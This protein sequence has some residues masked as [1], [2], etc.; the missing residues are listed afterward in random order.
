MTDY[1][2]LTWFCSINEDIIEV[3]KSLRKSKMSSSDR[4][5]I[6]IFFL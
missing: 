5:I 4:F 3:K 6:I 2:N 1:T